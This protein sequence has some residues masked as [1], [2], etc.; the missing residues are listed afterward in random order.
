MEAESKS[1]DQRN[2]P[3]RVAE[4]LLS[5]VATGAIRLGS[6]IAELPLS[7]QLGISRSTLREGLRLLEARGVVQSLPQKGTFIRQYNR[8]SIGTVYSLREACELR[9]FDL[10]LGEPDKLPGLL[11]RLKDIAEEMERCEARSNQTLNRLDILFHTTLIDAGEDFALSSIWSAIKD[12][13]AIIFSLELC[14]G[15]DFSKDHM[16]LAQALARQEKN[17]LDGEYR[18]HIA[19]DRLDVA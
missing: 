19:K 11:A 13:L 17:E 18:R 14:D 15:R 1:L 12:H 4:L 7:E 16:R 3:E 6:R 8:R 2:L 9:A 5:K 10:I